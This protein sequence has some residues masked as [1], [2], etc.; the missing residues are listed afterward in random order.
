MQERSPSRLPGA[1]GDGPFRAGRLSPADRLD[2]AQLRRQFHAEGWHRKPTSRLLADL[3]LHLIVTAAGLAVVVLSDWLLVD[4]AGMLIVT[5]GTAGVATHTHSSSHFAT[6]SRRS[7]NDLLTFFG[8][9]FF[10]GL[11]ATFW[12]H[13]HLAVHHRAPNVVGVDEDADLSPW[14]VLTHD[15]AQEAGP[16]ARIYY[17]RIQAWVL[18]VALAANGFNMQAQGWRFVLGA[19]RSRHRRPAHLV[20]LAVLVSHYAFWI[21][22]PLV[23]FSLQDVLLVYA[24]RIVLMGY[25]M[26]AILAPGHFPAEAIRTR[27][28]MPIDALALQTGA[29]INFETGPLGRLM[30]CG[31]QYQIEH[32]LFPEISYVYYP[33]VSVLVRDFCARR[34]LPYRS[35]PW[36]VA[37]WKSWKA[38]FELGHVHGVRASLQWDA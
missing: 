12:R 24:L 25:A 20:D 30:C 34:H 14:F 9:P 16:L 27:P 33:A 26:F 32:H 2:L 29:T 37:I 7:V 4:A 5:F 22:L 18:P 15:E 11:S 31:L 17:R 36:P 38:V 23:W 28:G 1:H 8:Y 6:S 35:Y 19:L 10:V 13:K 3:A 21:G